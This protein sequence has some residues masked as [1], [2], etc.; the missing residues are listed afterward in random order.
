[1]SKLYELIEPGKLTFL[2]HPQYSYKDKEG[3]TKYY[4][5]TWDGCWLYNYE[6]SGNVLLAGNLVLFDDKWE[7]YDCSNAAGA[8]KTSKPD[9]SS[10]P[11][12]LRE[13]FNWKWRL[14]V[15]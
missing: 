8:K 1:M 5:I 15:E 4:K 2:R 13:D 6:L 14:S 11:E 12:E 7:L 9:F 10:A 3:N